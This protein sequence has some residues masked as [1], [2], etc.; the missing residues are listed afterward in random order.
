MIAYALRIHERPASVTPANDARTS[1]NT[2]LTI[3]ASS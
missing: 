1:G 3:V 2:M